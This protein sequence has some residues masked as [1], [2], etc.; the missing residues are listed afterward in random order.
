MIELHNI[1]KSYFLAGQEEPVLKGVNFKLGDGDM[2]A[3]MGPSGS[4]KSTLMNIIG[5]L[6]HPTS[7][8]YK[9]N[10]SEIASFESDQLAEL[11]NRYIGFVFQSF[12]LLP[13]LTAL[14]NVML[15]L[16]YRNLS[17]EEMRVTAMEKLIKVGMKDLTHHKPSQLSGGQQQRVAI[18]RALVGEPKVILADEPTGALDAKTSQEVMDLLIDLNRNEGAT[19]VVVT[20][21]ED[22]ASQ[23]KNIS[24]IRDGRLI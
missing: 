22:V 17:R 8:T 18:A 3:L 15:P 2:V 4:G 21:D 24:R 5:L 6:D 19:I 14:Q 9:L 20:H 13:R 12:F 10:K 16:L 1:H 23:C 7:G 11:R